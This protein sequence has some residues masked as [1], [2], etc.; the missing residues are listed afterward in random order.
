MYNDRYNYFIIGVFDSDR[1]S[2]IMSQATTSKHSG[3]YMLILLACD[4]IANICMMTD[5]FYV[6][7]HLY[8]N[9]M[10]LVK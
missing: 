3:H 6:G 7:D 1:I 10:Y 9:G 5:Y 2:Q 8:I 4:V